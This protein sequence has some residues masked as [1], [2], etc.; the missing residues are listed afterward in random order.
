M[1][2]YSNNYPEFDEVVFVTITS[3]TEDCVYCNLIEYNNKEGL[4]M[5]KEMDRK[6][7]YI[8]KKY[9]VPG[10]V[11]PMLITNIVILNNNLDDECDDECN[12]GKRNYRIDLSHKKIKSNERDKYIKYF[13]YVSRMYRLTS[14]FASMSN[15]MMKSILPLTMWRLMD[16]ENLETSQQKYKSILEKPDDFIEGARGLFPSE[17]NDFLDNMTSRISSTTMTIHQ[18][19]DLIIYCNNAVNELKNVLDYSSENLRIE[20][21]NSPQYK[22]IVEGKSDDGCNQL[23][24]DCLEVIKE[25]IEN[26]NMKFQLGKKEI[27][28]ER[29]ITIKC[30]PKP[31]IDMSKKKKKMLE[32]EEYGEELESEYIEDDDDENYE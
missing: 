32:E 30:L 29:E 13:Q 16:K 12:N 17:S 2:Y 18:D 1:S 27:V 11:Y 24:N 20:Y 7:Y 9:F 21:I 15:L 3:I 6:I 10:K 28:K 25:R 14:E 23:L 22:I 26:K 4:L 8:R 5:S 31:G 19:F